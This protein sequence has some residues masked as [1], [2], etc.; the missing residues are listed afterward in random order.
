MVTK[1]KYGKFI[2]LKYKIVQGASVMG[3]ASTITGIPGS[4]GGVTVSRMTN[5]EVVASAGS[6]SKIPF[7]FKANPPCLQQR[8]PARTEEIG[9][10]QSQTKDVCKFF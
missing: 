2:S 6:A 3:E 10:G 1:L 8:R 7:A 4:S 9:H 5:G